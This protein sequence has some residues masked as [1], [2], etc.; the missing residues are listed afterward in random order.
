MS[1]P[2]T[3]AEIGRHPLRHPLV[4]LVFGIPAA[5]VVA[6]VFTIWIAMTSADRPI[7]ERFEKQGLAV[8]APEAPGQPAPST[9]AR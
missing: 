8:S 7:P 3:A 1:T 6:G 2:V 4:W 9:G 5:T